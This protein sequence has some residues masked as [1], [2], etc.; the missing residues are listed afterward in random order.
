ML[1]LLAVA[2]VVVVVETLIISTSVNQ[3]GVNWLIQLV[4]KTNITKS[5]RCFFERL[6]NL[7]SSCLL[8]LMMC[9]LVPTCQ[10][11]VRWL[12]SWL[13]GRMVGWLDGW[14]VSLMLDCI[15]E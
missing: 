7:M 12:V 10:Q 11:F 8:H 14:L 4:V 1:A 6:I 13:V 2:V 5:V 3:Q 15:L 9:C